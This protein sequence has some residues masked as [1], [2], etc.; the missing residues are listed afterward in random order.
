MD[1]EHLGRLIDAHAAALTLY[2]RQWCDAPEDAVQDAFCRLAL[3]PCPPDV[4]AAWLHRAVRN[5]A[6]SAGRSARRR[7]LHESRAAAVAPSW[8]L[9]STSD[10]L[11]AAAAAQA[12]EGLPAEQREVIVAHLWGGLTFEQI[13]AVAGTSASTAFRRYSAGLETLR[14]KLGVPVAGGE[15]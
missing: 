10:G 11:D 1:A 3:L 4:P 9:P 13:A 2:A 7:R 6:I 14:R 12:L 5:A 8:F 15:A